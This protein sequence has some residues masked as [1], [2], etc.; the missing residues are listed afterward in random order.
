VVGN[1]RM[2]A[3]AS[4]AGSRP[5][6]MS[7]HPVPSSGPGRPAVWCAARPVSSRPV[8]DHL[9]SSSGVRRSGRLVS[10]QPASG[11]VVSPNQR[12]ALWCPPPVR[13]D[14]P[15]SSHLRWRWG[16]D[17]AARQ[18]AP[19]E[20]VEVPVAAAPSSGSVNGRGLD[21]RGR[22]YR[23]RALVGGVSAADPAGLGEGGGGRACPLPDQAGQAGVR[24]AR[25]WRLRCGHGAGC[26]ARLPHRW[27]GCR[28]GLCATTVRGCRGA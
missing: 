21:D 27:R 3:I 1:A 7:T 26:S 16:P 10:T 23:G 4:V 24:S 13:P 17:G 20:R 12:P 28:P 14:A 8:S 2:P 22:R 19:R 9:G 18:P 6:C 11:R 5:A 25:G 15:V